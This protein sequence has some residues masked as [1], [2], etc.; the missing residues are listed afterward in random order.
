MRILLLSNQGMKDGI[1]GNPIMLRMRDAL[2][3]DSR[4]EDVLMLRCK[5]PFS[6]REELAKKA[7]SADVIHIHFG[8]VYALVVWLLLI[9]I[10]RPKLLTFHGTDIH[11]KGIKTAKT[12]GEKLRIKLNQWASFICILLYDQV[13]FVAEDMLE[14]V[15]C[16]LKKNMHNKYFI[17]KLGVDYHLFLEKSKE[18]AQKKLH[19]DN[20]YVYALFSDISGSSIKRRDIASEIIK[21][22]GEPYRLTIMCGINPNMVPTYINSSDFVLLTSDEEGSP[23]IIREALSLNKPIFSVEVGDAKKQLEG[24]VNSAI[25]SRDPQEAAETIKRVLSIPYADNT[26]ET[27]QAFLDLN[28]IIKD[29]IEIYQQLCSKA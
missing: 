18:D 15:P 1:V 26:R 7:R 10:K 20:R 17:Q 14:Y 29:V 23:N 24:L 22:L 25:I 21:T 11:A 4:V 27:K 9:R 13:G 19:L 5:H 16:F 28:I 2:K 12:K 8:G 3:N 6:V